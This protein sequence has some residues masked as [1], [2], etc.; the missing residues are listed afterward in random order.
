MVHLSTPLPRSEGALLTSQ[1]YD[2]P[3]GLVQVHH[4]PHHNNRP[5]GPLNL[6][7]QHLLNMLRCYIFALIYKQTPSSFMFT[8]PFDIPIEDVPT[9]P[10][11]TQ[12]YA[13]RKQQA[14]YPVEGYTD[15]LTMHQHGLTNTVGTC[16]TALTPRATHR[17]INLLLQWPQ[18][19]RAGAKRL[20]G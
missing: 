14:G 13:A 6:I 9:S 2:N 12:K 19:W 3:L 18:E 20:S 4:M 8:K 5:C 15:R 16:G 7:L 1:P 11:E 17:D 10:E